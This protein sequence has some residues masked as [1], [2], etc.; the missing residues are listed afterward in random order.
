[1]QADN[2]TPREYIVHLCPSQDWQKAKTSGEYRAASLEEERFI[3]CSRPDQILDVANRFYR[4]MPDLVLLWID[5]NLVIYD[6]R[7]ERPEAESEQDFPHIY[8]PL[9]LDAVVAVS[10]FPPHPDG[11]YR[12]IPFPE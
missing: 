9:N 8:G 3:H 12:S 5:P 7:Y 1:M 10:S 2:L 4:Q 11:F 6:I